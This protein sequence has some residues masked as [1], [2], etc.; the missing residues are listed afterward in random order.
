MLSFC[1][2]LLYTCERGRLPIALYLLTVLCFVGAAFGNERLL[3]IGIPAMSPEVE[4]VNV[5]TGDE[6]LLGQTRVS[7]AVAEELE[8][9]L[10]PPGELVSPTEIPKDLLA[11]TAVAPVTIETPQSVSTGQNDVTNATVTMSANAASMNERLTGAGMMLYSVVATCLFVYF[12][13]VACEYRQRWVSSLAVQNNKLTQAIDA[14]TDGINLD[15]YNSY[16]TPQESPY[17][18]PELGAI[19]F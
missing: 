16:S 5:L 1:R 3:R 15:S 2:N 7:D 18:L 13:V 12:F 19:R 14:I 11:E 8:A 17:Q 6:V 9:P 10:P 4:D